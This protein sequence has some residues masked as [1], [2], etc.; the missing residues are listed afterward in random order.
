MARNRT[1]TQLEE[2]NRRLKQQ[3]IS[4]SLASVIN[5]AIKWAGICV[6]GY[7]MMSTIGTLA[8]KETTANILIKIL[9]NITISQGILA[10]YGL[11]ATALY[12]RE[13][14]LRKKTVKH[15]HPRV[16]KLEEALDNKRSSSRLTETGDTNPDDQPWEAQ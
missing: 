12:A 14:I 6:L 1:K 16:K 7:E 10:A 2:E 4:I 8:G 15:V 3:H 9:G 5:T 13:R 11:G